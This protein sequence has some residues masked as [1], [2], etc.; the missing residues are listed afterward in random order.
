METPLAVKARQLL[1]SFCSIAGDI[2][3]KSS[4]S[5]HH[6]HQQ[7]QAAAAGASPPAAAAGATT[8]QE[9]VAR[10]LQ[11]LLPWMWPGQQ[12]VATAL[13]GNEGEVIDATR[14]LATLCSI[15]KPAVIAAAGAQVVAHGWQGA[16]PHTAAAAAGGLGPPSGS[17]PHIFDAL[18]VLMRSCLEAGGVSTSSA[19][20][21]WLPE[22]TELLLDCWSGLL[23]PQCGYSMAAAPPPA[24]A[25][26][27]AGRAYGALVSA[28]LADAA[29]GA[30]EEGE[31]DD[32]AGVVSR[33]EWLS[34]A[35]ALA[36]A[37]PE[38]SFPAL[39]GLI[40]SKQA[41]LLEV[42]RTGG[43][44]SELLEQ[45]EWLVRMA[46]H[47]L[48]D[49]GSG[50]VP[51]VPEWVVLA[52]EQ[53]PGGV[54]AVEQL[55]HAM[56]GVC[57][58]CLQQQQQGGDAG[59]EAA[60]AAVASPRLMETCCWSAA[61][62]VDTYLY[63]DEDAALP[64]GLQA[65]LGTPPGASEGEGAPGWNILQLLVRCCTQWLSS[66]PGEVELH[67]QVCY[68]LLPSL[69]QR[70]GLCRRLLL[71]PSWQQLLAAFAQGEAL[72]TQQ[73]GQKQQRAL[74]RSLTAAAMGC[75]GEVAVGGYVGQ[76]LGRTVGEVEGLAGGQQQLGVLAQRAD[77]QVKVRSMVGGRERGRREGGGEG[78]GRG[79]EG[80]GRE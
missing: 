17:P 35:A 31:T 59:A 18:E 64:V 53:S 43:D 70:K 46:A 47:A 19:S 20:E 21:P 62:W 12:A 68:S 6:H 45:L 77:V 23:Q 24:A 74:A 63:P 2:F 39:A 60:A 34:R 80:G 30:H 5:H 9:H 49:E 78:G 4:S 76:L 27:A 61:R 36:R 3:P 51:L 38:H 41:Q 54:A 13:A 14:A 67:G 65:V 10:M 42:A 25:L 52:V 33:S 15:H 22:V 71:L 79:G 7:Q 55:S 37:Q 32:T 28:A 58:L 44:P 11:G 8:A 57:G 66:Y 72:L 50:E 16:T 29:A 48:A 56:L 73:L 26:Q 69:V 40:T 75:E 1:V